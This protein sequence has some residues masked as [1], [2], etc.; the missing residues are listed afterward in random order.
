[1]KCR[2]YDERAFVC[3]LGS[4]P[5][6]RR[7]KML[8]RRPARSVS[9]WGKLWDPRCLSERR[10]R[11]SGG[12]RMRRMRASRHPFLIFHVPPQSRPPRE[13]LCP[14]ASETEAGKSSPE[15]ICRW[16]TKPK[17]WLTQLQSTLFL[18]C[19]GWFKVQVFKVLLPQPTQKLQENKP[20]RFQWL[21]LTAAQLFKSHFKMYLFFYLI[22]FTLF[23]AH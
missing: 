17:S 22:F 15:D 2:N 4:G 6:C 7:L 8:S 5:A 19:H 16:L 9:S 3:T 20:Y 12:T 13:C 23:L 18:R 10:R 14:S 1:M 21:C 11:G